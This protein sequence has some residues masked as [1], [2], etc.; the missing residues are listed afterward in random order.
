MTLSALT[1]E[2]TN[3]PDGTY[4]KTGV[5][6][7]VIARS[8]GA[9]PNKVLNNYEKAL[10]KKLEFFIDDFDAEFVLSPDINSRNTN[11]TKI[12]FKI[13]EPYSMGLFLN[14]LKSA[15]TVCGYA[16]YVEACFL[17]TLEFV[18][19][20]ENGS[21]GQ[22]P[23]SRRQFPIKFRTVEF[24]VTEAGSAYDCTA[25]PWNE[26]ALTDAVQQIKTDMNITGATV[27]ELLQSGGQSLTTIINTRLLDQE[28]KK[29]VNTADQ[30][31]IIFPEDKTSA[32]GK[33]NNMTDSKTENSATTNSYGTQYGGEFAGLSGVTNKLTAAE[34]EERY[35]SITGDQEGEVP[36]D[37][38]EYLATIT[39][40][41]K[42]SSQ[43]GKAIKDYANSDLATNI[44]GKAT[45]IDDVSET[46]Q[47]P[48]GQPRYAQE[49]TDTYP[50]FARG[51]AQ[52][53]T[54]GSNRMFKFKAGTRIQDIIEEVLLV[55]TY[56]KSLAAQ[57]QD[58]KD[59][60]GMVTWYRIESDMY[61]VPD[62]SEVARTGST[63]K[64][65][66][67][68]V[69]PYKI[70]SSIFNAP[71]A[72][73]VGISNL[74]AEAAKEYNYIYTGKNKDVLDFNIEYKYAFQAGAIADS[75]SSS[76]SQRKSTGNKAVAGDVYADKK[77]GGGNATTETVAPEG[78]AKQVEIVNDL[79]SK[80]GG[81]E[82]SNADIQ[83]ARAFND[84]LIKSNNDM[85]VCDM[86]I[87]GDPFYISDNGHGNFH[88]GDTSYTNM[89]AEGSANYNNGQVH[90]NVLFKTPVDIS[91]S[92]GDYT[93]PQ[94]V[95]LVEPF[96]GLYTVI[97]QQTTISSNKFTQ[98]LRMNRVRNQQESSS[99]SS[100][101]ALVNVDNPTE[102]FQEKA[103]EIQRIAS[104]ARSEIDFPTN[105]IAYQ[106]EL[107]DLLPAVQEL[108]TIAEQAKAALNSDALATFGKV[109]ELAKSIEKAM[110]D[111][112]LSQVGADFASLESTLQSFT[113]KDLGTILTTTLPAIPS[114]DTSNALQKLEAEG[115]EQLNKLNNVIGRPF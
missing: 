3:D 93:F 13:L 21:T 108:G 28:E 55:S 68:R 50:I 88:A 5:I 20:D 96:S 66:V 95:L 69:V 94:D 97:R 38:D 51:N 8:G 77:K 91:E 53:Q 61:T 81:S 43:M 45:I 16:N 2:Q 40:I 31:V 57:L 49:L 30:Y 85:L 24:A 58:I 26:Q 103:L 41:V 15:A 27:R 4:R 62:N 73:A 48:Q 63:P 112:D 14:S 56:G 114:I 47:S 18:G 17:F 12:D 44:I 104:S 106:D 87:L 60:S 10:G 54:S 39:G 36:L 98:V 67:Y 79:S 92:R 37:Y 6:E 11:A 109:G 71:A 78:I 25:Y 33:P 89:T 84:R 72:P 100:V 113:G 74:K 75:G 65:Y 9:G 99:T 101:S 107:A 80:R 35:R 23:Y 86:E 34:I 42:S 110:G 111:F 102:S 29:Q 46:G 83:I 22:A 90:V 82:I 64:I 70:H 115:K 52:L 76:A 19:T 59:P 105:V 32:T 1:V 7:N